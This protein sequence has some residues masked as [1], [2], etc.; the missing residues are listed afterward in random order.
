[1]APDLCISNNENI[2]MNKKIPVLSG[3]KLEWVKIHLEEM[4]AKEE[5]W[6]FILLKG[7]DHSAVFLAITN[8]RKL[9]KQICLYLALN[10][11]AI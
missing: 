11:R 2:Q 1:M 10:L 9:N 7:F 3:A 8:A 4:H 6:V 5:T